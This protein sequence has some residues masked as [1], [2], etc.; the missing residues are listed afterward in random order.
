MRLS[1]AG[2]LVLACAACNSAPEV[3]ETEN[4]TEQANV[5]PSAGTGK[6]WVTV[7]RVQ[8]RTC[9]SERCGDVGWASFRQGVDALEQRDNWVRITKFYDA[10]CADGRSRYVDAGNAKCE[11]ANGI[12]DG[13]FAEWIPAN[14][15]S[16]LRPPDP[17]AQATV[18]ERI[19]AQSDDFTQYHATF[20][21]VAQRLISE[22]RCT[23]AEFEEQGGWVKSVT[24]HRNEPVYFA[25]CGGMT[26]ANKIYMNA[27]TG[28]IL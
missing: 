4:P 5:P 8:R 24:Q 9:P 22:G 7:Q 27:E 12:V 19:V 14:A 13:R 6:L 15:L 25:Y 16:N 23:A 3:A 18:D 10:N 11:P 2:A 1:I 17:A 20:A 28:A 21:R 26:L